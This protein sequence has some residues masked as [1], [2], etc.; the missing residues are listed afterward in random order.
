MTAGEFAEA[1]DKLIA[2]A[3][4]GVTRRSQSSQV[5]LALG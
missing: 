1:I 4:E 2:T 5:L 3:R